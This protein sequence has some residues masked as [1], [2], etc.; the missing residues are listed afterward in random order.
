MQ[1]LYN[2]DN[3]FPNHIWNC[4]ETSIEVGRQFGTQVFA[5]K[6]SQQVYSTILKSREW[7]TINCVINAVGGVPPNFYIFKGERIRKD[8]IQ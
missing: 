5:K 1:S 7:M 8:Y 2:K 4:D 3:Y 6:G